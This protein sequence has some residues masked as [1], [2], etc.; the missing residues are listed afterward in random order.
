MY[1][2]LII[3]TTC[4]FCHD[5]QNITY[6]N[7]PMQYTVNFFS[8]KKLK[9]H[10][11][12]IDIFL[13]FAQNIDCEYTLEPPR[14]EKPQSMFW[15]NTPAY[16]SFASIKV[17]FEGVHISRTCFPDGFYRCFMVFCCI[18]KRASRKHVYLDIYVY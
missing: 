15:S 13:I 5:R 10:Q 6:E 17:G 7:L 12:N 4:Y 2:F 1:Y 8:C 3:L 11:K 14:N 16:P 18:C 9:F